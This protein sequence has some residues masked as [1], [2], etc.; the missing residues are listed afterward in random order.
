[1]TPYKKYGLWYYPVLPAGMRLA[2]INDFV[3]ALGG[4]KTDFD[5]LVKSTITNEFE[6]HKATEISLLKWT[7]HINAGLVYIKS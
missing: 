1:M 4:Y 2:G 5:F 7:D 3:S 6:S